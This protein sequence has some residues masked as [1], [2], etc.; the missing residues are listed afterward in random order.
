MVT[1]KFN[2]WN[3]TESYFWS[4]R[5]F[6]VTIATSLSGSTRDFLKLSFYMFPYKEILKVFKSKTGLDIS[7]KHLKKPLNTKLQPSEGV[8]ELRAYKIQTYAS[9]KIQVMTSYLRNSSDV[10]NYLSPLCRMH[11]V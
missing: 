3:I 10:T 5:F 1:F 9:A 4:L 11:Y 2:L 6:G 8:W 7:N